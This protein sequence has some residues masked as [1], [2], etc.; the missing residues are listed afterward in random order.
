MLD[1]RSG[2]EAE[3]AR[4]LLIASRYFYENKRMRKDIVSLD[5]D[6]ADDIMSAVYNQDM[7]MEY[8]LAGSMY[9]VYIYVRYDNFVYDALRSRG[10]K[11]LNT[12][13][14][15]AVGPTARIV[16]CYYRNDDNPRTMLDAQYRYMCYNRNSSVLAEEYASCT[17]YISGNLLDHDEKGR[18]RYKYQCINIP[19]VEYTIKHSLEKY[20]EKD[21]TPILCPLYSEIYSNARLAYG[22]QS[23]EDPG[24]VHWGKYIRE[25]AVLIAK[26]NHDPLY[27]KLTKYRAKENELIGKYYE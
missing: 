23:G 12:R 18:S 7:F 9:P 2:L 20:N 14:Q 5:E 24:P 3:T 16:E 26:E 4:L 15:Y 6:T 19:H 1:C 17:K 10:N 8:E 21:I 13:L 11:I 22:Y 27:D 25:A